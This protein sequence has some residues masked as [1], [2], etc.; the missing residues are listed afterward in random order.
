MTPRRQDGYILFEAVVAMA[1]LSIGIVGIQR[2]MQQAIITR[3]Q[4]RDYTQARFLLEEVM[5]WVELQP[6]LY[7]GKNAGRFEGDRSRFAWEWDITKID[8]PEPE[9]PA[10]VPPQ[11]RR[12]FQLRAPYLAKIK[13]TVSWKRRGHKYQ[14][15]LETLWSPEKLFIPEQEQPL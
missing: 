12:R 1:L 4:A 15:S 9:I 10:D 5:S 2:A 8:F 13:V 6:Q 11:Q 7:T 3:G 14:E